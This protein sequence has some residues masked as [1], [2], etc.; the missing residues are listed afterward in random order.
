VCVREGRCERV[1]GRERDLPPRKALRGLFRA[2]SN[3]IVTGEF[4]YRGTS[5]IRKRLL[6]G[7]Y[8]GEFTCEGGGE[9]VCVREAR[10]VCER[11]R[12]REK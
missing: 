3:V 6:L 7:P 12:E 2:R 5:R 4:T 11:G 8:S 9:S 10:C 1:R